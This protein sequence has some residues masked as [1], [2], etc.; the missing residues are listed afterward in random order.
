MTLDPSAEKEK[1]ANAAIRQAGR[2]AY[3]KTYAPHHNRVVRA[4][5]RRV[6]DFCLLGGVLPRV[7]RRRCRSRTVGQAPE[8]RLLSF[9][10]AS[11]PFVKRMRATSR[12][13]GADVLDPRA[14]VHPSPRA[15]EKV[16]SSRRRRG[17]RL[18]LRASRR[19]R[20]RGS[21]AVVSPGIPRSVDKTDGDG[22]MRCVGARVLGN[23]RQNC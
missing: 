22:R 3:D 8:A 18:Q 16:Y 5:A 10:K 9:L 19:R 14:V 20:G 6:F 17:G 1:E 23:L 12:G 13:A 21:F 11:R 15:H 7:G 4:I 2:D